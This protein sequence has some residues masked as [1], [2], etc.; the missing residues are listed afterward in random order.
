MEEFALSLKSMDK[1]HRETIAEMIVGD[2]KINH[3]YTVK[4]PEIQRGWNMTYPRIFK[5]YEHLGS[6]GSKIM[7][8]FISESNKQESFQV[9]M[10]WSKILPNT[11]REVISNVIKTL[12]EQQ[13]IKRIKR[14]EFIL[15]PKMYIPYNCASKYTKAMELW[16]SL[17]DNGQ[18][19][20]DNN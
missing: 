4:Y 7:N 10:V 19:G 17:P 20:K 6:K 1:R 9:K 13:F 14:G 8:T 2:T 18:S 3:H 15:N 11:R 5:V 12:E 16:E